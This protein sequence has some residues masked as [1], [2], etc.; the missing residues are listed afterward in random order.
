M[1]YLII[2]LAAV[3]F[4][5]QNLVTRVLFNPYTFG[6]F[7]T[8]GFVDPNLPNSFLLLFMRMLLGVPLMALVLPPVYPK[9]WTDLR[10][11][12]TSEHR[13][14]LGLALAGGILMF[15]YLG[16]LYVSVGLIAAGIALTLFF[17]FPVYTA[18]L[19]WLWFGHRPNGQRWLIMALILVGSSLTVPLEGGATMSWV[20]V[21]FGLL[22]AIAYALYTVLA[23]KAFETVHPLPYTAISFAT[24]LALSAACMLIW[25]IDWTGLPWTGLWIGALLSAL[26]TASGHLLNNVG[27]RQVGA[28]AASM[29]GAANPALTAVLAGWILLEQLSWVQGLGVGLVTLSVA[30]LSLGKS[31]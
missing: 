15:L 11:L 6:G 16:L 7:E 14:D 5:V 3:C 20:G 29:V 2:L 4:A 19:S 18:L 9:L 23:Q 31:S 10:Q 17:T 13:R 21:G 22:S 8:G 12:K 26:S 25:P 24:T 1:G 30:L 28:T 27:I